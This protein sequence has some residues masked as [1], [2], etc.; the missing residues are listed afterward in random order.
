M[1]LYVIG[2]KQ[3]RIDTSYV[4]KSFKRKRE[5]LLPIEGIMTG[6]F[7]GLDEAENAYNLLI[8]TNKYADVAV[9]IFKENAFWYRFEKQEN[10]VWR[11]VKYGAM[12]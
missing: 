12:E 11:T 3:F 6:P 2:R 10:G 1:K 9:Y 4:E 5:D 8:N 7:N